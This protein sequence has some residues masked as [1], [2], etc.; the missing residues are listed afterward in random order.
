MHIPIIYSNNYNV[1]LEVVIY[2]DKV[3]M[4]IHA[5]ITK[6]NKTIL[7]ELKDKWKEFRSIYTEDIYAYA[8]TDNT[9]K[10]A[11]LFGFKHLGN[12]MRNKV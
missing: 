5:D 6:W 11:K 8:E 9:I 3:S 4:F 7:K 12:L 2:K 10:F 1:C